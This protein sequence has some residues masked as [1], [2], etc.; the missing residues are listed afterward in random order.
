MQSLCNGG[1]NRDLQR[2]CQNHSV[3]FF[4]KKLT[5]ETSLTFFFENRNNH[6]RFFSESFPDG[7]K[8][9]SCLSSVVI[10]SQDGLKTHPKFYFWKE[11][12]FHFQ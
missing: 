2:S 8:G 5:L 12:V 3:F 9:V 6:M 4:L 7:F 11:K 1:I 10:L